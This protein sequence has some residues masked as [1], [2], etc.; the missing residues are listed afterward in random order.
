MR[1]LRRKRGLSGAG[2]AAKMTEAGIPW[3]RTIVANL[4]NGRRRNVSVAELA[5]LA[6]VLDVAPVHL[7]VPPELEGDDPYDFIPNRTAPA[8][9]VREWVRGTHPLP[10]TDP[11]L[12]FSE[13][14]LNEWHPPA[15]SAEDIERR[16]RT[17]QASREL[18]TKSN[19]EN[20]D[21]DAGR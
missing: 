5:A 3:D 15:M 6:Y 8:G 20:G 16:S 21:S 1:E 2:L 18:Q 4:E 14:P 10:T 9:R 19:T 11:R 12:F 17:T 7:L 13:V